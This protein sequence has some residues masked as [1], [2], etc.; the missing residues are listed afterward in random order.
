MGAR[1][2]R[3]AGVSLGMLIAAVGAAR[4][5]LPAR[6]D[7]GQPGLLPEQGRRQPGQAQRPGGG[8]QAGRPG[9]HLAGVLPLA[10][11][12]HRAG[13][14]AAPDHLRELG[15]DTLALKKLVDGYIADALKLERPYNPGLRAKDLPVDMITTSASG[16]DPEISKANARLQANRVAKV[17]GVPLSRVLALVEQGDR[18]P[19]PRLP[20]RARRQRPA[21]QPRPRPGL[22]APHAPMSTDTLSTRTPRPLFTRDIMLPATWASLKKLDPRV[23][24]RNPVMFVVEIGAAITTGIFV[25]DARPRHHRLAGLHRRHRV[26]AVADGGLRQLRRGGGRGAGQG[27]GRGPAGHAQPARGPPPARRRRRGARAG[28]QPGPGR[29]GGLRARAT[30]SR[31]TARWSRASPRWTSRPSPA[32]RRRSSASPAATAAPSPAA[33]GCS[34]T[35]SSCASPRSPA[36]ASSTA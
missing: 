27:P 6:H 4:R 5:P 22:R 10:P 29:P 35:A 26:L 16:I 15:P 24:I 32:S 18:R 9:L 2:L 34:R 8:L 12:G 3:L 13:L 25:V 23:Q 33:P 30:S 11:L 7:R 20:R 17:R 19:R 14:P 28:G 31:P 36:R 1:V 21:A